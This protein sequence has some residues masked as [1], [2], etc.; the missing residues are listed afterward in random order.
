VVFLAGFFFPIPI[1]RG[2]VVGGFQE[3]K[4]FPSDCDLPVVTVV[5]V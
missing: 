2:C 5:T 1:S 3:P 4:V